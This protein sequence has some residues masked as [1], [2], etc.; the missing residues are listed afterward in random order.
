[1]FNEMAISRQPSPESYLGLTIGDG[2]NRPRYY[3]AVLEMPV[4]TARS[5]ICGFPREAHDP[6]PRKDRVGCLAKIAD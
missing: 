1:M 5:H 6:F 3:G 2:A 4:S